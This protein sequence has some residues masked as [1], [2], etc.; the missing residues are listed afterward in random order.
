[1]LRLPIMGISGPLPEGQRN[2]GESKRAGC[3]LRNLVH[4]MDVDFLPPVHHAA[5]VATCGVD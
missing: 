5:Q 1:M 2:G 3:Y 4:R